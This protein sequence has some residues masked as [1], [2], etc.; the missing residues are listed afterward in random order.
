M[1]GVV[2]RAHYTHSGPDANVPHTAGDD[3]IE[4]RKF[5]PIRAG[6]TVFRLCGE[7][8]KQFPVFTDDTRKILTKTDLKKEEVRRGRSE[9]RQSDDCHS[10]EYAA[11]YKLKSAVHSDILTIVNADD[12]MDEAEYLFKNGGA[13]ARR[14]VVCMRWLQFPR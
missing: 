3:L 10:F 7:A 9:L 5:E 1:L 13:M 2:T 11:R 14:R 4:V 8:H 12:P 6:A